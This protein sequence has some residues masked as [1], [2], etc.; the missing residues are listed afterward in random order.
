M[1]FFMNRGALV[2]AAQGVL[3]V[4]KLTF[5]QEMIWLTPHL[6]VTRLYVNTFCKFLLPSISRLFP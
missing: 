6:V 1:V 4:V 5:G 2:T 3:L